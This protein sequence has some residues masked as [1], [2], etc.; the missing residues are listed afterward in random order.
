MSRLE[1]R[2]R[3]EQEKDARTAAALQRLSAK[4][5][6]A[7][8][9]EIRTIARELHDE[10]GQVLTAVKM[11]LAHTQRHIASL[12]GNQEFLDDAR[13]ITDRALDAASDI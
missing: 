6:S 4:L 2:L 11:G 1:R 8:E 10:I 9:E 12:G 13:S 5:V 7:Q 3:L